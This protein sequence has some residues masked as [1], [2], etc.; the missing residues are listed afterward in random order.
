MVDGINNHL[1]SQTEDLTRIPSYSIQHASVTVKVLVPHPSRHLHFIP[2]SVLR[3][4]MRKSD[5]RGHANLL[6]HNCRR[7]RR[8]A[9]RGT[10]QRLHG[11]DYTFRHDAGWWWWRTIPQFGRGHGRTEWLCWGGDGDFYV[12]YGGDG[13]QAVCYVSRWCGCAGCGGEGEEGGCAWE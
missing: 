2:E 9:S 7:L 6:H 3:H 1:S 11:L 8:A 4:P 10:R 5:L 13:A 12:A